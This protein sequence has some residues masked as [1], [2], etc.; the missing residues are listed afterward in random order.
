[1]EKEILAG[2]YHRISTDQEPRHEYCNKEWCKYLQCQEENK[3]FQH[4]PAL[5]PS[6]REQVLAVFT[7]LSTH[8]LLSRCLGGNTQ[9]SNESYNNCI[10]H[11]APKTSFA[12]KELVEIASWV[13]AC[14]FNEGART[15]LAIMDLMGIKI[16]YTA[17]N[18][19]E[20]IDN[21]RI[22]QADRR[23]T[24]CSKEARIERKKALEQR[25]LHLAEVEDLQYSPGMAE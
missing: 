19:A 14:T 2:Y 10:W 11:I 24:D 7:S 6:V 25:I 13:A 15:Y 16:G 18:F 21:C 20:T 3:P 23:S 22:L 17:M 12:G 5:D 8:D 9:N 1:M 4:K